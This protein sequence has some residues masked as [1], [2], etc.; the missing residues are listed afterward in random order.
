MADGHHFVPELV[1][2]TADGRH[3][4]HA[5][6]TTVVV[7]QYNDGVHA[8]NTR[9]STPQDHTAFD[10]PD[11]SPASSVHSMRANL[12][13][14]VVPTGSDIAR[15]LDSCFHKKACAKVERLRREKE[16]KRADKT[17]QLVEFRRLEEKRT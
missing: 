17:R 5:H 2:P 12:P 15:I 3:E 13:N 6:S 8:L 10:L 16:R 7:Q 14:S 1:S 4:T 11:T 9:S